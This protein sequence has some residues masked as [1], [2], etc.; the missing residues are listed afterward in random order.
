MAFPG[1]GELQNE[2]PATESAVPFGKTSSGVRLLG[3]VMR[4]VL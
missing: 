4:F 1:K 3:L 2:P